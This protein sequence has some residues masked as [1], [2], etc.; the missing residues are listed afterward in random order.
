LIFQAYDLGEI[1]ER[2]DGLTF[3]GYLNLSNKD[4]IGKILV[5]T[6]LQSLNASSYLRNPKLR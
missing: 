1:L 4:L 5:T 2:M 3:L 6:Q